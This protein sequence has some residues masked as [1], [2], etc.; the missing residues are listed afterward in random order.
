MSQPGIEHGPF[1]QLIKITIR[2]LYSTIKLDDIYRNSTQLTFSVVSNAH[3]LL[4]Q[5]FESMK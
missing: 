4:F 1:E 3:L 2:N 5:Q